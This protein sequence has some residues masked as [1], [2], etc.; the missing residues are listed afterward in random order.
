MMR[1]SVHQVKQPRNIEQRDIHSPHS[2]RPFLSRSAIL[3]SLGTNLFFH[4]QENCAWAI[5]TE[6]IGSNNA[7][8]LP[9]FLSQNEQKL[10]PCGGLW[11]TCWSPIKQDTRT[12]GFAAISITK[13]RSLHP[14]LKLS[15]KSSRTISLA[16]MDAFTAHNP[17]I[18]A[19]P[20]PAVTEP[21]PV[22]LEHSGGGGI[23]GVATHQAPHRSTHAHTQTSSPIKTLRSGLLIIGDIISS[24]SVC[25]LLLRNDLQSG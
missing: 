24:N 1:Q 14:P 18:L 9:L 4:W 7:R 5:L 11:P 19:A 25:L 10:C 12:R 15:L 23:V 3:W 17:I 2:L 20:V 21:I 8:S 13:T 16:H 22:E 6:T